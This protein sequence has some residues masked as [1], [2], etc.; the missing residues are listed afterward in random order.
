[1]DLYA[2]WDERFL[3]LAALVSTWSKDPSTK[4][5]AVVV[6]P[7]RQVVSLGYNGFP[8]R[9]VD[10]PELYAHRELKYSRTVHCEMNAVLFAQGGVRGCTLYTWPCISCDRCAVH[11]IQAGIARVVA[12]WP[13]EDMLSRWGSN[14]E[15]SRR[16]FA[17][18]GVVRREYVVIREEDG[19]FSLE[20]S[21][22]EHP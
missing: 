11:M 10:D 3:R 22:Q 5:G 4:C 16:Y 17:E 9:L 20:G 8:Q 14:L 15:N 7:A 18:A 21:W 12:P 19:R 2:K 1:M 6:N 13:T